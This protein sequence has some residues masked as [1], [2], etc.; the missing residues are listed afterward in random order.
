MVRR[1]FL[2]ALLSSFGCGG[3]ETEEIGPP[4]GAC[5]APSRVIGDRC[6]EPGVQDDGCPAG[7]LGLQDGS[8]RPAGV[9][10]ELCAEGF[11]H[12]GDA[13]CVP[14][15]P[16]TCA[17]GTMAVPG[18]DSCHPVM[19]CGAGPW[20]EIPIDGM[21]VHVDGAYAGGDSDGSMQKPWTTIAE[22]VVAAAPGALI[23]I[24][25]GN[26]TEEV[27][28]N[29]SVRLWG[30]CPDEVE[31][32][33]TSTGLSA[34]IVFVPG[35]SGAELHGVAVTGPALGIAAT[36]VENVV[37]ERVWIHDTAERGL[38]V[39]NSLGPA[40]FELRD[41]LVEQARLFGVFVSGAHI[42]M[43]RVVVRDTQPQAGSDDF[44]RGMQIQVHPDNQTS[45]TAVIER[46]VVEDN[47]DVAVNVLGSQATLHGVVVRRTAP[48]TK[49]FRNGFGLEVQI[50]PTSGAHGSALVSSTL[51]DE[52]TA[53]G[54]NV[55]GAEATLEGVVVRRTAPGASDQGAGRGIQAFLSPSAAAPA[56]MILKSS[57][58]EDNHEVGVLVS[59]SHAELEGVLVRR[60]QPQASDRTGGMGIMLQINADEMLLRGSVIEDNRYIG[61]YVL[62]SV[63][64]LDGVVV[65]RTS[66][67]ESDGQAG[68]GLIVHFNPETNSSS[69][70]T[71]MGSIFEDSRAFGVLVNG[72]QAALD[73]SVVRRTQP[74]ADGFFGDGI[75]SMSAVSGS[76]S[77]VASTGLT[78]SRIEE[79]AR[80]GFA[81]FG[82]QARLGG[83]TLACN[84][85]DLNG[86]SV[87]GLDYSFEDHGQNLCGCPPTSTCAARSSGLAPPDSFE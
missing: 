63:A 42:T 23:A 60:T 75:A 9:P 43:E 46:T 24:A 13:A 32:V 72:G 68:A 28:V 79:S 71:V 69:A 76:V 35:A 58:V 16:E 33:G 80:A 40:S 59:T 36:G 7:T 8:C 4:P 37:L 1:A 87:L 50:E 21:T 61:V 38:D 54:V 70:A 26:Y 47:R 39:E 62:G 31:I 14:I 2:L 44:G 83:S 56:S 15:L 48:Q 53:S 11:V 84:F 3:S 57:L 30:K 77:F 67:Q 29:K 73:A 64:R 85:V 55:K 52:S 74:D 19:P 25:S 78:H 10:P 49:D 17:E 34:P 12:D 22:A 6:V 5:Q 86:E 66:P 81:T 82:A 20:G 65:R 51:F 45:A 41:V 18:E 27:A